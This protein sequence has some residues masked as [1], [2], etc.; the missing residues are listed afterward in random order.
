MQPNRRK[1]AKLERHIHWVRQNIGSGDILDKRLAE[2]SR[3]RANAASD[4]KPS[5]VVFNMSS[6]ETE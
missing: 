5:L 4:Q 1:I 2:I 3:L 6:L